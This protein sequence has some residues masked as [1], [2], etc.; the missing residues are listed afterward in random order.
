M[1]LNFS[2]FAEKAHKSEIVAYLL[3]LKGKATIFRGGQKINASKLC[4]ELHT[5]DKISFNQN[6]SALINYSDKTIRVKYP[7]IYKVE[8]PL[9]QKEPA[10]TKNSMVVRSKKTDKKSAS[11]WK[12]LI[13][14]KLV[15]VEPVS[16]VR[17]S[18]KVAILAPSVKTVTT[19]PEI[20]LKNTENKELVVSLYLFEGRGM[21]LLGAKKTNANSI[22]WPHEEWSE[23][24][25]GNFYQ[26]R[27]LHKGQ[28]NHINASSHSFS[29]FTEEELQVFSETESKLTSN[30]VTNSSQS[31]VKLC[32]LFK[33]DCFGDAYVLTKSLLKT[34]PDNQFLLKMQKHCYSSV[35]K[36]ND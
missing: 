35:I 14:P 30:M 13:N 5:G 2:L 4:T 27:V 3:D 17:K 32:Q 9:L 31:I 29:I 21:K 10:N 1:V 26:L 25:R 15:K 24:K 18:N 33:N 19:T 22:S 23:L 8:T 20:L 36:N 28:D 11:S 34:E 12:K 16:I 6:S 7:Q